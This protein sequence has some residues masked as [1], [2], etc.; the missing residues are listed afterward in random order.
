MS[1]LFP[2]A[3]TKLC[4]YLAAETQEEDVSSNDVPVTEVRTLQMTARLKA[5]GN[6]ESSGHSPHESCSLRSVSAPIAYVLPCF[7]PFMKR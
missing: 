1:S 6:K 3:G 4:L 7:Y 5:R 2:G